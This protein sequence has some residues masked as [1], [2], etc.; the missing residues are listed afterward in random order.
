M[1]LWQLKHIAYD[2]EGK[3][4]QKS[5]NW[6]EWGSFAVEYNADKGADV[7][8]EEGDFDLDDAAPDNAVHTLMNVCQASI[9]T[10][11]ALSGH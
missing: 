3:G 2:A 10:I 7:S 9:T 8:T 6:E 4:H 11:N 5:Y 1:C